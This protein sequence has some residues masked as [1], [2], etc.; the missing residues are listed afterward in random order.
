MISIRQYTY[1]LFFFFFSSI[2]SFDQN[3][4]DPTLKPERSRELF[5]NYVDA[6]QKKALQSDYKDDKL[7]SP[8][9]N[10]DVNFQITNALINK[11]NDLQKKIEKD[12]AM[13]GQVKVLYIRG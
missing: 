11:V 5:H 10:K 8:T 9:F 3:T 2:A 7:F 6:K 1:F 12:S 13:G 4:K